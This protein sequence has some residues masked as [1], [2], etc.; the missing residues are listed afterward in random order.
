MMVRDFHRVIGQELRE[1]ILAR[2]GRLPDETGRVRRWRQQCHRPAST[3]SSMT[4][5][6]KLIGVEAGGRGIRPGEHAARFAGGKLGMLQGS[7]TYILQD[8]TARLS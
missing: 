5:S 3:N 4:K 2:E 7:K 6:V 1:Q 8:R